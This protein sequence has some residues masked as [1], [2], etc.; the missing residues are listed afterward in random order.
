MA[1]I[2]ETRRIFHDD[3]IALAGERFIQ[4]GDH[5]TATDALGRKFQYQYLGMYTTE[6]QYLDENIKSE[7]REFHLY[8]E[9]LNQFTDVWIEWF[10]QRK[11]VILEQ[12][13]IVNENEG[14]NENGT[15]DR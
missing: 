10:S 7:S 12:D 8:N 1:K 4:L 3:S 9:T 6:Y 11:I 5:F 15:E 13:D 2:S 14:E